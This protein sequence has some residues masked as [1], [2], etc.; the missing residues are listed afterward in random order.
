MTVSGSVSVVTPAGRVR[1]QPRLV[2]GRG[3]LPL[4]T[5]GAHHFS[6]PRSGG[7]PSA[8]GR[9]PSAAGLSPSAADP[10]A[11]WA[12]DPAGRRRGTS[13]SSSQQ[14][15]TCPGPAGKAGGSC[16]AQIAIA[17]GHRV[18]NRQPDGGATAL[19]GAP[20]PSSV[21]GVVRSGSGAALSSSWVYG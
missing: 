16:S 10:V 17:C 1:C 9:S 11:P 12:A 6:S 3:W 19:G 18:R 15:L 2:S 13:V 21:T 7:S 20:R 14:E 4:G 5:V 8:A